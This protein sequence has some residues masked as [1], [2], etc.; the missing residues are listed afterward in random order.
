[1]D[2]QQRISR[3]KALL[4]F[5]TSSIS[6]LILNQ[7]SKVNASK[8]QNTEIELDKEKVFKACLCCYWPDDL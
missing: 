2:S 6:F 1:M 5:S 3:R 8:A 7:K 4:T